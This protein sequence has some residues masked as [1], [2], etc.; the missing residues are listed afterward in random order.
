MLGVDVVGDEDLV[1]ESFAEEMLN[2]GNPLGVAWE[3]DG[4]VQLGSNSSTYL[5]KQIPKAQEAA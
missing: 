3:V 2:Q 1:F 5:R 4:L